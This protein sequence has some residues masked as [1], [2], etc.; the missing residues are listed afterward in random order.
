MKLEHK[1]SHE[2]LPAYINR[3]SK[4]ADFK[5]PDSPPPE[6]EEIDPHGPNSF[7]NM[8]K[9]ACSIKQSEMESRRRKFER[10][11]AFLKAGVYYTNKLECTRQQAYYPRLFAF[12][13]I[14]RS[15][16]LEFIRK[17]YDMAAR[18]YEEAYSC[19]RYFLSKNPN[20]NNE[21]IDDT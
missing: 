4:V 15:A 11:P 1:P 10:L 8:M 5:A 17:E 13:N 20:W 16:S 21:G 14:M 9:A 2:E 7:E 12:E 18:K 19:W 6:K 3:F